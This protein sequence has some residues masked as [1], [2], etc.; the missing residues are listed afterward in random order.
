MC[1]IDFQLSRFQSPVLDV[2]DILFQLS[3][4]A[5]RRAHYHHCIDFYYKRLAESIWR[6][7]SDPERLF[8]FDDMQKQMKKF[9][10]YP[11]IMGLVAS[12]IVPPEEGASLEIHKNS[13]EH[14]KCSEFK[15][16]E[17]ETQALF[18]RRMKNFIADL[19]D[20]KVL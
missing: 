9:N 17:D 15:P 20:L 16:Y 13:Q 7:G 12:P 6:F 18:S 10:K 3:D 14:E 1:F 11:A 4:Q 5:F 19:V 8:S 2:F